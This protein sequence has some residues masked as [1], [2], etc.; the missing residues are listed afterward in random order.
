[1]PETKGGQRLIQI[2]YEDDHCTVFDKP[3]GLLVTPAEGRMTTTLTDIVNEQY[4]KSPASSNPSHSADS[5]FRLHPCHR[6]DKDT[7][8]VILYAKGKRNQQMFMEM[9]NQ[10]KVKKN[11]TAFV[12]GRL[13]KDQGEIRSSIR[14][15]YQ[16]KFAKHSAAKMAI[17]RYRLMEKHKDYSVVDV[18]PV[19][20]R[21][22]QI[23]IHFADMKHPIVGEDKYAFRKDFPLR[24][25]RTALHARE[26]QWFHPVLKKNVRASSNVPDD[27]ARFL[28]THT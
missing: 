27:M 11:Y 14:D 23:R 6:L 19:T 24:F 17:T 9:F 10:L 18:M 22:N 7:S 3:P 20:G 28:S 16:E 5:L 8:G 21:T 12:H 15:H 13:P 2:L 1:M 25:K 26:L 4:S